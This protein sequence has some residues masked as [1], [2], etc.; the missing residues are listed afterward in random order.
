MRRIIFTIIFM[1]LFSHSISYAQISVVANKSYIPYGQSS[2]VVLNYQATNPYGTPPCYVTSDYG[3][4]LINNNVVGKNLK[5]LTITIPA[6]T[7]TGTAVETLNIPLSIIEKAKRMKSNKITYRRVFHKDTCYT[8]GTPTTFVNF[9]ITTEASAD[10]DIKR[11]ELYFENRRAEITV[12]KNY[13]KLK[14]FADIKFTGSGLLKGYWEVDGRILSHVNQHITYGKTVTFQTPEIPPLPTFEPGTHIVR[15][16]I[17][18]P[19]VDIPLPSAIYFVTTEEV[20]EI[21]KISLISPEDNSINNYTSL[22]FSWRGIN[23]KIVYLIQFFED[24]DSTPIFSAYTTESFYILPEVILKRIFQPSKVYYWKVIGFDE[25]RNKLGESSL[26]SFSFSKVSFVPDQILVVVAKEDFS[27]NFIETLKD[28]YEVEVLES[29]SLDSVGLMVSLLRTKGNIFNKIEEMEKESKIII[30]QPNYIFQTFSEPMRKLQYVFDLMKIDKLH[31]FFK[32]KGV[33]VAIIDTGI[34]YEHK[35]LKNRI[36]YKKNFVRGQNYR[37]E[38]HGTAVA[39]VIGAEINGFGI[40]GVAPEAEIYALRA[41]SQINNRDLGICES[42]D[43]A[44]AINEAILSSVNIINMSFGTIFYDKLIAS[45]IEK[46][47]S[48]GISMVSPYIKIDDKV[49]FPASHSMV[50]SVGGVDE[51]GNYYPDGSM[52]SGA[53]V[54]APAVNIFTTFPNDK[55]NFLSGVSL[56]TAYISGLLTLLYEKNGYIK[57]VP[58]FQGN[59]CKW[60]ESLFSMS[61]CD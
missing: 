20:K 39:G 41:C 7:T 25:S 50:I 35:D 37:K 34:D 14:A 13:K 15:F 52:N 60:E 58:A 47:A 54:Y 61:F 11:V 27:E 43:I 6:T 59:F 57:S 29:F 42:S 32:G 36:V 55:Y 46:A 51:K 38:I 12:P 49:V 28:K 44:K 23:D 4:F 40:A 31:N 3:E 33:K 30:V 22:R 56:S 24:K 53:K 21:V 16:V 10:F 17:T 45:L 9:T 19:S 1:L 26:W 18:A 8:I 48:S 5:S 2:V